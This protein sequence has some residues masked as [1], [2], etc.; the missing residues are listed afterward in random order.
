[1]QSSQHYDQMLCVCHVLICICI[2]QIKT[3]H[4]VTIV[5]CIKCASSPLNQPDRRLGIGAVSEYLDIS[6][7]AGYL[8]LNSVFQC[9]FFLF[10]YETIKIQKEYIF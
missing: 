4:K 8:N 10:V 1:M 2:W 6:L 7:F 5:K 3:L 9:F